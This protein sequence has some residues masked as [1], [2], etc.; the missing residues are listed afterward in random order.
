MIGGGADTCMRQWHP[1]R[2]CSCHVKKKQSSSCQATWS[3]IRSSACKTSRIPGPAEMTVR[4]D[5]RDGR[6]TR[7]LLTTSCLL[8]P[9]RTCLACEPSKLLFGDLVIWEERL[10]CFL[11]HVGRRDCVIAAS[12]QGIGS[13]KQ[14]ARSQYQVQVTAQNGEGAN[15]DTRGRTR[16]VAS[17]S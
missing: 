5:D 6:P 9:S 15:S 7:F 14:D 12:R 13:N 17:D 1:K 8:L 10:H 4:R 11:Y 16:I 2:V 3:V